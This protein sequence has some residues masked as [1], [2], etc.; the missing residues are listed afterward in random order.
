THKR[1]PTGSPD[2]RSLSGQSGH[3]SSAVSDFIETTARRN[4]T[5][6]NAQRVDR[7]MLLDRGHAGAV[8]FDA[9]GDFNLACR[10]AGLDAQSDG[11]QGDHDPFDQRR[12]GAAESLDTAVDDQSANRLA[13][14]DADR[15]VRVSNDAVKFRK[16]H[17]AGIDIEAACALAKSFD[18]CVDFEFMHNAEVHETDAAWAMRGDLRFGCP[19]IHETPVIEDHVVDAVGHDWAA[20]AHDVDVSAVDREDAAGD[21]IRSTGRDSAI[22][23]DRI[24]LQTPHIEPAAFVARAAHENAAASNRCA[25]A[26]SRE[27]DEVRTDDHAIIGLHVPERE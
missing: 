11:G 10:T 22:A 6:D 7:P 8:G 9:A 25:V 3:A 20:I 4:K 27:T 2:C 16:V 15:A 23:V 14:L 19:T 26:A 5:S 21:L 24:R 17:S 13:D 12:P 1:R 18:R